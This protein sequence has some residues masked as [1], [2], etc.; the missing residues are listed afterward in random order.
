[1]GDLTG[2]VLR[3]AAVKGNRTEQGFTLIELLVVILIIAILAAIAI[4]VF[5]KQRD[6]SYVAGVQSTLK[7]AA[8]AAESHSTE[9]NGV[10]T[11]LNGD[12]GTLLGVQGFKLSS[13]VTVTVAATP[14]RYCVTAT[15]TKL[16][17]GH[18]WRISTYNS[19]GGSPTPADVD[20][21][22]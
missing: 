19:D 21:C 11:G 6:K 16:G 15:Q 3:G 10:F 22:P 9:T 4:P 17:A 8:T 18:P 7:N 5:L 2:R 1:V 20:T 13:G 14:E 12:D